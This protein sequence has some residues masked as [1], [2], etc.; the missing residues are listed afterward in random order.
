MAIAE[1]ALHR[2]QALTA[3]VEGLGIFS[4]FSSFVQEALFG[5]FQTWLSLFIRSRLRSR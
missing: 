1:L 5:L 2:V 4:G 3:L